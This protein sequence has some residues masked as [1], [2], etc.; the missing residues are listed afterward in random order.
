[1]GDREA[2]GRRPQ[3]LILSSNEAVSVATALKSALTAAGLEATVW[4]EI[5][6]GT[7]EYFLK[8]LQDAL[9]KAD[10][11][12][13]L[14]TPD[15]RTFSRMTS[16]EV[17]RDNILFELGLSIGTLGTRRTFSLRPEGTQLKLPKDLDGLT[18][19][20][21][22]PDGRGSDDL[23]LA[24]KEIARVVLEH[25]TPGRMSW[26][27]FRESLKLLHDQVMKDEDEGG[28][29]PHALIGIN[30]GGAIAG[31]LMFYWCKDYPWFSCLGGRQPDTRISEHE[32]L[33]L[34]RFLR[35][36]LQEHERIRPRILLIDD[37]L[38]TGRTMSKALQLIGSTLQEMDPVLRVAVVVDRRHR[39]SADGSTVS[40]HYVAHSDYD[41]LPY[42]AL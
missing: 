11:A 38:S 25:A 29:R 36:H 15:D 14:T 27:T 13:L 37:A 19:L 41:E 24:A 12:V 3:V 39:R 16:F 4:D 5:K 10:G 31:G 42:T 40:P 26:S 1:V 17:P 6:L 21:Y 22:A 33:E 28:F 20:K 18:Y 35:N 2:G 8:S 7:D 30:V 9:G 34:K 32:L 23:P